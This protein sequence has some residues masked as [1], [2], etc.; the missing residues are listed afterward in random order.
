MENWVLADPS[1]AGGLGQ[2][3]SKVLFQSQE[4]YD[5]IWIKKI[6]IPNL[7]DMNFTICFW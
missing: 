3:A 7:G 5:G 4:F 1:C 2:R 6:Q